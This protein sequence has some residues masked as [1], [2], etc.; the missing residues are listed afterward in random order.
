MNENVLVLI[1]VLFSRSIMSD[2]FQPHGLQYTRLSCPS[3]C[4]YV[5]SSVIKCSRSHSCIPALCRL[6]DKTM[7]SRA[8]LDS[9]PLV[10]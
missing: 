7:G 2:S 5:C 4:I 8:R 3:L 1:Y 6:V 10:L 9:N